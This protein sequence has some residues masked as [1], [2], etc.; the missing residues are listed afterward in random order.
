M[1]LAMFQTIDDSILHERF[2]AVRANVSML[3]RDTLAPLR[4][5]RTATPL[6]EREAWDGDALKLGVERI[7]KFAFNLAITM[8]SQR[9]IIYVNLEQLEL[10][11]MMSFK[12]ATMTDIEQPESRS[13]QARDKHD[14]TVQTT[15]D[16][17]EGQVINS[18]GKVE[19]VVQPAL[20][21][22]GTENGNFSATDIQILRK[23]KVIYG[24]GTQVS[25]RFFQCLLLFADETIVRHKNLITNM[26]I[27]CTK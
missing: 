1:M 25:L 17:Y 10:S 5:P 21:R 2:Q 8:R 7:I 20:W 15:A 24:K 13:S 11:N 16:G 12:T 19:V 22:K 6:G 23:S 18:H 26:N 3:I 4:L 14:E 27:T 9:R